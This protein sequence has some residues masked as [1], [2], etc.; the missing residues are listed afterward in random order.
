M[1]WFEV[2]FWLWGLCDNMTHLPGLYTSVRSLLG[3]KLLAMEL[4]VQGCDSRLRMGVGVSAPPLAGGSGPR[5]PEGQ[6]GLDFGLQTGWALGSVPNLSY[7][8]R[9]QESHLTGIWIL[10][11]NPGSKKKGQATF[12]WPRQ[13]ELFC[14]ASFCSDP[15]R[16]LMGSGG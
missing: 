16:C 10:D 5:E 9:G 3:V 2:C 4:S 12:L 6:S 11:F 15:L 13:G 1:V 8:G 7:L 14:P